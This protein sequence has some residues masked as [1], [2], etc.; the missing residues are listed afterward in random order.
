MLFHGAV[1]FHGYWFLTRFTPALILVS[2]RIITIRLFFNH[3]TMRSG[4]NP[5][6]G[7]FAPCGCSVGKRALWGV[8][9]KWVYWECGHYVKRKNACDWTRKQECM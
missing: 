7:R 4:R 2:S 9:L 5:I 8:F 1:A 3:K 6:L